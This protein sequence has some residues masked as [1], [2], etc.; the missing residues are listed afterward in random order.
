VHIEQISSSIKEFIGRGAIYR[1][2]S[3]VL[4]SV[5]VDNEGLE[6]SEVRPADV[7]T[8]VLSKGEHG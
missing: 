2:S 7:G 4:Y 5:L 6:P 3:I 8:F 1:L